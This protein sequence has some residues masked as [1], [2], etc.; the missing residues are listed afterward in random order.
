VTLDRIIVI[1]AW[2]VPVGCSTTDGEGSETHIWKCTSDVECVDADTEARC[3]KGECVVRRRE[4][5]AGTDATSNGHDAMSFDAAFSAG[6]AQSCEGLAGCGPNCDEDCSVSLPVTGGTFWRSYDGV[7]FTDK[8]YPA[9]ISDFSLD[10]YEVTV[11]RFREFVAAFS[12]DMIPAGAG[13][14][15]NNATDPGWDIAWNA[16]LPVDAGALET[17][18]SGGTWTASPGPNENRP[19]NGVN[20]YEAFAF[21]IWDGGRLPTEAE[22]NYAAAGGS[23]QRVYPWGSTAPAA[24]ANLAVWGCYYNGT[25]TCTVPDVSNI[26]PVGS[27]SAGNGKYGQADL[28]GNV[29]EWTLDWYA[30]YSNPCSDCAATA[31]GTQRVMR[32][33]SF[34]MTLD[35]SWLTSS[36]RSDNLFASNP[37][38]DR[39]FMFGFRCARSAP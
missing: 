33:G 24:D 22:W 36:Y 11:G 4:E 34:F 1:V 25:G 23:E 3:V 30:D 32:G 5:E 16:D 37:P 21:C 38:A 6:D 8:L 35:A 18:V 20:W 17:A 2:A 15:P 14:N 7:T 9:T 13:K 19:I 26:A 39:M 10:K 28:I 27:A 12:Q 29:Q 31:I